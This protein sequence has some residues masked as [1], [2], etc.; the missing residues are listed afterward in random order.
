MC[1]AQNQN[2]D[3]M[4]LYEV[5]SELFIGAHIF[6]LQ[7]YDLVR[8]F[9]LVCSSLTTILLSGIE[10]SIHRLLPILTQLLVLPQAALISR[11]VT[12]A[13]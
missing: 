6:A 9:H 3:A 8:R 10:K 2:D 5:D 1:M 4:Y 12:R 13:V 7:Y 11:T